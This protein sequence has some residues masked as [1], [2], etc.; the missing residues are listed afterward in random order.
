M[1]A[2]Y[3]KHLHNTHFIPPISLREKGVLPI[4]FTQ[5]ELPDELIYSVSTYDWE[6]SI[7]VTY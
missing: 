2:P 4:P 3:P 7:P 6:S 1:K 5:G